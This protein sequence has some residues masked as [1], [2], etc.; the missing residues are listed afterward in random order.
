MISCRLIHLTGNP[1]EAQARN[2]IRIEGDCIE[3][4]RGNACQIHLPDHRVSLRHATIRR[5]TDGSARIEAAPDALMSID[6]HMR[7]AAELSIATEIGIGPYRLTVESTVD[8]ADLTILVDK[9]APLLKPADATQTAPVSLSALGISKRKLGFGLAA[10]ILVAFLILP[11]MTKVSPAFEAWQARLPLTLTGALNPGPL[12]PGHRP[13]EAKCSTCHQQAFHGVADGACTECHKQPATHLA[14]DHALKDVLGGVRCADCHPAHEG[15]A[16]A[17][18]GGLP[19]CLNCH[20][21]LGKEIAKVKDFGAAH[22]PFQLTLPAGRETLRVRQD[23]KPLP[24]ERSGFKFSHHFHLDK[25]GVS[26]PDGRTLLTCRDCHKLE[27]AGDHFAP[28]DMKMTCQQSRC[29][30]SRFEDPA[31]GLVPHG[32][33]REVM[34][35]LRAAYAAWLAEA[36]RENAWQCESRIDKGG[37]LVQRTLDCAALLARDQAESTFF[38]TSGDNLDCALCHEI[39]ATQSPEVPWKVAPVRINRDWHA[40]AVFPH[41]RHGTL[42]CA[43][44]HDKADS[45]SSADISM[46]PIGKC[47]ECHAGVKATANKLK[48]NCE[49]CHRFHRVPGQPS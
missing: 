2:E 20:K 16:A 35:R 43:E 30:R 4:G 23:E 44:C 31:V 22:P 9:P 39:N 17:L 19:T 32:S 33:E 47:R 12:S 14:A 36:P 11:L 42:E 5:G 38:R 41:A 27:A 37:N 45:K 48:T 1:R 46:P 15:K 25:E 34:G 21:N 3:I 10:V 24:P 6:G 26:S 29:H 8:H 13:F 7:H 28:I 49:D 18:H 40:K